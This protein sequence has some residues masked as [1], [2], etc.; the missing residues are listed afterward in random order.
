MRWGKLHIAESTAAALLVLS[1]VAVTGVAIYALAGPV[2][3][4][5]AQAPET[6]RKAGARLRVLARPVD[7]VTKA[8]DQVERVTA[9]E[10][11]TKAP[12]VVVQGPT[13][14]ARF[15]GTTQA[16]V[17]GAIEVVVLLYFLLAAGDFFLEKLVKMLPQLGDKR[18]A[19]R[20]ARG[21]RVVDFDLSAHDR[22]HQR[23]RRAQSSHSQCGRWACRRHTSGAPW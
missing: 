4:W 15:F 22:R 6:M 18:K 9:V 2:Q 16:L 1:F 12:Q 23:W 5:V 11:P 21:D 3:G 10:A 17:E 8:A 13:L 7:Q 14:A 19:V 20:I